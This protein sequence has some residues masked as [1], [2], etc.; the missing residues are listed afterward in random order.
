MASK[1][2]IERLWEVNPEAEIWWDSS[3][4]IYDNWRKKMIEQAS[5]KEE[6][7]AWLDRLYSENNNPEDNIFRGVTTNPPLSY[8]AIKDNPDYWSKWIDDRIGKDRCTD[9]EVVFWD[10]YKEIVKRG[11]EA[12]L[13]IFEATNYKY[14]FISGQVDPRIRHDVEK[15][16]SQ[17]I[18][19]HSLSPNV[20]IKV[21]GTAEGY[22]VIK[23]LTARAIPTNNTLAF[24]IPQFVACMNAVAEG[25][26]EAKAKGVDLSKWRSVITAMSARYGT[27][28]DLQK[29][30][31]ERNI[32]L[33][34]ADVRWAEIAIFKK[35]CRLV[36]ENNEYP[37]KMLLCSMRMSPTVDG[38]VRSWH[39]EKT[40]GANAVFT[41]PP[42]YLE[43]LFFKGRH[44][45]F[46][47]QIYEPVPQE[48]MD[49][50]MKIPYFEKGYAEDGYSA[51]EFN[52]HPALLATAGQFSKATQQMV[53]FV[54]KR[55]AAFC[56]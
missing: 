43:G 11:A 17:G 45:E 20:M 41:C 9:S 38:V 52:S 13:P 34:E 15:M 36:D 53:D 56:G 4:L 40:A 31:Q 30:A 26:K 46:S 29:E 42:P 47:N 50:L 55:V 5:D 16:V 24:I 33:S 21:P 28:G 6:M 44:L 27:L 35:A 19:L 51:E 23:Q 22:E 2:V 25:I 37:G 1:S 48:V 14:G 8:N 12:Y 3:P 10:T 39:V 18:E 54:A 7:T 49:K 32:E